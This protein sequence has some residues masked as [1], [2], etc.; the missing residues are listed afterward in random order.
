MLTTIVPLKRPAASARNIGA[1]HRHI[2][3]PSLM[4]RTSKTIGKQCF[5]KR[6]RAAQHKRHQIIAPVVVDVGH[7]LSELA[8][9][10]QF[11]TREISYEYV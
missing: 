10:K 4:L 8:V 9:F 3:L 2:T 6:E 1:V 11:V 7:F 5:F